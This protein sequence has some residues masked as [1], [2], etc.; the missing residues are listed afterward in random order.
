MGV[1]TFSPLPEQSIILFCACVK[2][3]KRNP[4]VPSTLFLCEGS[5]IGL[6]DET[7]ITKAPSQRTHWPFSSL[8]HAPSRALLATVPRN[9]RPALFLGNGHK[10]QLAAKVSL[11]PLGVLP[12]DGIIFF[13]DILTLPYGLGIPIEMREAVGPVVTTPLRKLE[14]FGV[15]EKYDPKVHTPFVQDALQIVRSKTPGEVA[16]LGFAGAPWTVTSYLTDGKASRKFEAIRTWMHRDPVELASALRLLGQATAA[17]LKSQ[18][19]SGAQV[20][21]IFDTVAFGNASWFFC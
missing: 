15:F 6:S 8:G 11:T 21:Q 5:G 3:L 13:S 7:L 12:V 10:P 19:Q 9:P 1:R 18:I 16:L 14:D 2:Y 20:V 17:Y 4:Q